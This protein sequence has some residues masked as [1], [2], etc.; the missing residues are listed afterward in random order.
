MHPT[1]KKALVRTTISA[2]LVAT[3]LGGAR[4]AA[5]S[6]RPQDRGAQVVNCALGQ[7]TNATAIVSGGG[8]LTFSYYRADGQIIDHPVATT[9]QE[10]GYGDVY[11]PPVTTYVT[12]VQFFYP[13][14]VV[15]FGAGCEEHY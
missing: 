3:A 8:T 1:V 9:T 13:N 5:A 14:R 7:K 4:A 15:S 6:I 11:T 12:Q 10:S 2:A